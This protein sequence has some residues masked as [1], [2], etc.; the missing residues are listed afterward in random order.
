[1]CEKRQRYKSSLFARCSDAVNGISF[2]EIINNIVVK[3][4]AI[5][6]ATS[7]V[8]HSSIPFKG[9][10]LQLRKMFETQTQDNLM[11]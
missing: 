11:N 9:R 7:D 2:R 4:K 1:M 5:K 3:L 6:T 10:E 8:K